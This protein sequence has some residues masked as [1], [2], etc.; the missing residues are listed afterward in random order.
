MKKLIGILVLF[1][2]VL[3]SA[4][5]H[6][7]DMSPPKEVSKLDFMLGKWTGS[8]TSYMEGMEMSMKGTIVTKKAVGGRY[9]QSDH[10]Y[11]GKGMPEMSGMHMASYDP[12]TKE[13][14]G[15]WFDS[16]APGAMEMRGNFMGA[17]LRMVS[18]PTAV[19]GMPEPIVMRAWYTKVSATKI[20][21]LLEMKMGNDW[22]PMMKG[23]MTKVSK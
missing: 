18:K 19:P 12:E 14:F 7:M 17:T 22:A 16:T 11:S 4:Q 21:F 10:T 6:M 2:S 5:D 1:T 13:Y 3:V 23:T 9:V 8:Y 20:D 15:Y